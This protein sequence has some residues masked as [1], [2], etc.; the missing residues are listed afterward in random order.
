MNDTLAWSLFVASLV[1][2]YP[3]SHAVQRLTGRRTIAS[4]VGTTGYLLVLG[5]GVGLS[6]LFLLPMLEV[7]ISA[8]GALAGITAVLWSLVAQAL[9]GQ[10]RP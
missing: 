10:R 4:G 7:S 1:A 6:L 2:A 5:G 9:F 8:S 3:L